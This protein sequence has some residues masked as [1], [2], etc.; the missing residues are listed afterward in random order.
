M[1]ATTDTSDRIDLGKAEVFTLTEVTVV[2]GGMQSEKVVDEDKILPKILKAM[3]G[4][5]WLTRVS[6]VMCKLGKTPQDWQ[7][8]VIIPIYKKGE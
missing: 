1:A 5:R 2:I 6:Q 3:N 7:M 8:G 4:V